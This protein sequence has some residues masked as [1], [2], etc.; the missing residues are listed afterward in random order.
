MPHI[1]KTGMEDAIAESGLSSP[2]PLSGFVI[3]RASLLTDGSGIGVDKL[4]VGWERH[5]RDGT[6]EA[7]PGPAVGYTVAR[8][9]VGAWIFEKV[10]KNAD[11]EWNGRLV[12]VTS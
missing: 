8:K 12:T 2:S 10:V 4:R 9:D 3:V 7:G 5:E 11:G 6:G 1:D